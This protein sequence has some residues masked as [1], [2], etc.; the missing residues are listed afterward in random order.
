MQERGLCLESKGSLQGGGN[1]RVHMSGE[2]LEEF[3]L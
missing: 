3:R 2:G 1:P